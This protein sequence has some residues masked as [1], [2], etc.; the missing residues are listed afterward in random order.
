MKIGVDDAVEDA[1]DGDS[2]SRRG[3]LEVNGREIEGIKRR[4]DARRRQRVQIM[5]WSWL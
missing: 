3:D 5:M 2:D 1:G 4:A